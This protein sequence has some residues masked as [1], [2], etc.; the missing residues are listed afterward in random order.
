MTRET[1]VIALVALA[2]LAGAAAPAHAEGPGWVYNRTVVSVVNTV[3]GGFNVRFSPELTSCTS[4]GY[5]PNFASVY[6]DHAGLRLL[7]AD[8]LTALVTG[9][10]VSIYLADNTCKITE[11]VLGPY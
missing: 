3:Y 9:K 2:L 5:G 1:R 6:P 7:K 11:M 4:S 10:P 8:M